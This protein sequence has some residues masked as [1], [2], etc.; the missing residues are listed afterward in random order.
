MYEGRNALLFHPTTAILTWMSNPAQPSFVWQI[1]HYDFEPNA[2]F[3][4]V[5]HA[6]ELVHIQF[7]Q[8]TDHLQVINNLPQPLTD[9]VAHVAIYHLDGSVAHQY[10]VNVTARP[11]MATDLGPVQ[12]P[13]NLTTTHLIKLDLRDAQGK[14]ISSNFYWRGEPGYP[15]VLTDLNTMPTVT[16]QA[17]AESK[18]A[19]GQRLVTVTLHNPTPNIALM[20][21][22]QLRRQRTGERVLPVFYSDNYISLAPNET[23]TITIQAAAKDFN[24]EEAQVVFDGWNVTVAPASFAGVSVAPNLEAQPESSPATGLPLQTTSLR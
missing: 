11:D 2:S 23:K 8:E 17:R 18:D 21:H 3:F 16:L 22:L 19:D 14:L 15:D 5:M 12:F 13:A 24:G 7:N 9:A 20:A 6:S 4:G 1:Y 10:D